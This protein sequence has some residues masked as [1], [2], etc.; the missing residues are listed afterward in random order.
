[1]LYIFFKTLIRECERE[2]ERETERERTKERERE[3]NRATKK[4]LTSCDQYSSILA[5]SGII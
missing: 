5:Q 4:S 2:R 1:M 3:R